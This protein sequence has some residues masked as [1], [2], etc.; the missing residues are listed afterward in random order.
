MIL[1]HGTNMEFGE[2][3]LSK[4]LPYKD[5]GKGFYLTDI[6]S[7][8]QRMAERK[9]HRFGSAV[10]QAYEVEDKVIKGLSDCR[11]KIFKEPDEEWAMFILSNRKRTIPPFHHDYDI[12]FGPVADDG[13]AYILSRY[14]EGTLSLADALQGLRYAHLSSQYCFCTPQA[15]N[16]LRRIVL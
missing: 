14:E 16:H 7:Q 12:V 15:I 9:S 8:A 13:I 5:F 10:V 3:D 11:V 2:I 4:S 6:L 1:Y